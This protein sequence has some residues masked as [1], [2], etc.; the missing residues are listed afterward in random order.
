LA[1]TA[2]WA[3]PAGALLVGVFVTAAVGGW[4]AASDADADGAR[5][6]RF[7][8]AV[9]TMV[10][11]GT[12][13]LAAFARP[14][15]RPG[16]QL[17][18]GAGL[19][20]MLRQLTPSVGRAV[21]VFG[22]AIGAVAVAVAAA[23]LGGCSTRKAN[24]RRIRWWILAT[25]TVISLGI[26][27]SLR[28]AYQ[29][30][31][32][33]GVWWPTREMTA[34]GLFWLVAAVALHVTGRRGRRQPGGVGETVSHVGAAL[35]AVALVAGAFAHVQSVP[36]STGASATV[37]VL[38]GRQWTFVGQGV[39]VYSAGDHDVT[40]VSFEAARG[41]SARVLLVARQLTYGNADNPGDTTGTSSMVQPAVLH[42][43][44][45]DLRVVTESTDGDAA[46]VRVSAAPLAWV[47]WLGA[48]LMVAGGGAG[49]AFDAGNHVPTEAG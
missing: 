45:G 36:L 17:G 31:A 20:P 10:F 30:S 32:A 40:A 13:M 46:R 41:A 33:A 49:L 6:A 27:L 11:A 16:F 8:G 14:Y 15:A 9:G 28:G 4:I 38:F 47:F 5:V 1:V 48:L 43:V 2:L 22:Y 29:Y 3:G 23:E 44:L 25:G 24:A 18:N 35:V 26:G 39:S 34:A 19:D 21:L 37:R 42:S 12:A 7:T